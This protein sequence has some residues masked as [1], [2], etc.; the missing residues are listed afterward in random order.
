MAVTPPRTRIPIPA[1]LGLALCA[2]APARAEN[3]RVSLK[4]VDAT[5]AEAGDLLSSGVLFSL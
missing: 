1:L 2:A 5:P 3:P 4:V